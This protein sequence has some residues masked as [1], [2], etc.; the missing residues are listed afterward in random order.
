VRV[1]VSDPVLPRVTHKGPPFIQVQGWKIFL[2]TITKKEG[3][4][5]EYHFH[6][7]SKIELSLN[8]LK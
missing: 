3:M 2:G 7:L 4:N 6:S 5:I 8:S 1:K